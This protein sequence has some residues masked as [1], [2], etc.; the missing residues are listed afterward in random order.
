MKVVWSKLGTT[1]LV[2]CL[3]SALIIG[4]GS[5]TD[6]KVDA[7]PTQGA[8]AVKQE[9]VD[10]TF[11]TLW[12]GADAA[13]ARVI[14]D[15]YNKS[16]PNV[17]VKLE[18][19]ANDQY[20]TKLKTSILGQTGPDLAISHIGG[21][22]N[23]LKATLLPLDDEA[24]RLGVNIEFDKY[25]K[26]PTAAAK[27]GGKQYSVPLDNLARVFMYNKAILK[28]AGLLDASGKPMIG[29]DFAGFMKA[30]QQIKDKNPDVSPLTMTIK[31]P[32]LV[33]TWLTFY[34]QLGGG[35]FLNTDSKKASFDDAK[36]VSALK[37]LR[38]MYNMTP[39][40][41]SDPGGLDKFKAKKA[42]FFMDGS[43]SI[44][45]AGQPLGN[46][47]GVI[48]FPK[49][50]DKN[51]EITTSHGFILPQRASRTDAQTKAALEFIKWFADNN[52]KWAQA[53]HV[54]GFEPAMQTTE[55]KSLPYHSQFVDAARV[56]IS[57][58]VIPG[59]MLHQAPEVRDP[60]QL[61]VLGDMKAEEAVAV[62]RTNLDKLLPQLIK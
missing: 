17:N 48:G 60:V 55:F 12:D 37:A 26:D 51:V 2:T 18:F 1:T 14:V 9:K 28:D 46:D 27:I 5:K 62:I 59:T 56:A 61:A 35:A 21:N 8:A 38:E 44:S 3:T 41:L 29:N 57:L 45:A 10:L 13:T 32:Q 34:Y 58:P 19:Q 39:P 47:Y 49:F 54:P 43:W 11:W 42:A 7:N 16:H 30:L 25:S 6:V 23:A 33:L 53:G 4:C 40:K 24:K 36:A 15:D 20:Y 31:P 22:I 50:F 52:A